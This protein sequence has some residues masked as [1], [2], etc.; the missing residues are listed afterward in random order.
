MEKNEIGTDSTIHEHIKTIQDRKYA[1]KQNFYFV[2]TN[3]GIKL[4]QSYMDMEVYLYKPTLRASMEKDLALICKG[5]KNY[6][7]CIAHY[8]SQMV[9]I[10]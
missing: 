2:P 1:V 3:L 6:S 8:L 10:Y 7:D 9:E 5:Q 4:V